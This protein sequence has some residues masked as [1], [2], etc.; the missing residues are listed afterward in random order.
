[1]SVAILAHATSTLF[2]CDILI[3]AMDSLEIAAMVSFIDQKGGC[4]DWGALSTEFPRVK[5][6]RLRE[7]FDFR[8]SGKSEEVCNNEAGRRYTQVQCKSQAEDRIA[9]SPSLPLSVPLATQRGAE[10]GTGN[11]QIP[12]GS[13]V[14]V[15]ALLSSLSPMTTESSVL[16]C[17]P[18][19]A[20]CIE[21]G[22]FQDFQG[23]PDWGL[24]D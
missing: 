11:C 2:S 21:A 5:A 1:M 24:P 6:K 8:K 10:D 12:Y 23:F 7:L 19:I 9:A 22:V 20:Q 18:Q 14:L 16:L 15:P 3:F 13:K 4:V 17:N